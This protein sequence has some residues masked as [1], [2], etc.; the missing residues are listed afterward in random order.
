M[1]ELMNDT[2]WDE[3]RQAMHNLGDLCPK[4][5]TRDVETGYVCPWDSDWYY[6]LSMGGYS[7]IEW[8]EIKIDTPEQNAIVLEIL[9]RIHVP[10]H[11]VETGFR[12]YGYAP[13]GVGL[14]YI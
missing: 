3:M 12:V 2:K 4:W 7:S 11:R 1:Q 5:R 13:Y 6:H 8:L 10:G 9:R 14:D